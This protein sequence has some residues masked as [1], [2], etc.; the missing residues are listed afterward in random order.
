MLKKKG[1]RSRTSSGSKKTKRSTGQSPLTPTSSSK[2]LPMRISYTGIPSVKK[3]SMSIAWTGGKGARPI[4][5]YSKSYAGALRKQK[6]QIE[7]Q[8]TAVK[9]QSGVKESGG[10]GSLEYPLHIQF[11]FFFPDNR[12]RDL[13]NLITSALD[14]LSK[15]GVISNDKWVWSFDGSRMHYGCK[16][17]PDGSTTIY[18]EEFEV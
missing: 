17:Q 8:W 5:M 10:L 15:S 6:P 18:I 9:R 4:L 14:L 12:R 3:N 16:D 13:D 7:D 11:T 1:S 2:L